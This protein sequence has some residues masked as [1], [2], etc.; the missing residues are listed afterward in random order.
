MRNSLLILLIVVGACAPA[1]KQNRGDEPPPVAR[2]FRGVW[3]ASVSNIDWPSKPGLPVDEQKRELIA[4][5]DKVRQMKMNA[6][7]LQVRPA[8]DALYASALEPWSEYLTG[9][10]GQAPVPFYDPLEFAVAEAHQRGLE[11]HAWFNP[12]R[13]RHPS[14]QGEIAATHLR[15]TRPDI[16]H[17]YGKHLWMDPGEPDVRKQTLAV[18]LDVVK[19]YDIDGI[20]LDDYFYPYQERDSANNIIPFPD[21]AS[22]N[23]YV[24]EGGKLDRDDWRRANVDQLIDEMYRAI[25][26]SKAWV[27]FG[28]SP[29]GIWRPGYPPQVKG[30]DAYA[31]LYADSKKWLNNGWLDYWTPQ[32]YWPMAAPEQSYPAL[33][34]WWVSENTHHRHVWP[35]NA[36]YRVAS[37]QQNWPAREIVDQIAATRAQPGATGNIHFSMRTFLRNQAGV[38][39]TV[40]ARAYTY[41]ALPPHTPWLD[42]AAPAAPV[43]VFDAARHRIRLEKAGGEGPLWYVVWLRL[44]G[45][46][47]AEVVSAHQ[48]EYEL[49]RQPGV[50]PDEVAVT[51]VDRSGNESRPTRIRLN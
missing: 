3:V 9:T 50:L 30:F 28:I 42:D 20:H 37:R 14:A 16:V 22:F 15:N 31:N 47:Y 45:V 32:L 23:R 8:A 33:L 26:Q 29:F 25:K 46:W 24:R 36:P 41:F 1:L 39:D 51:A 18:V 17:V 21:N 5:F 6:V 13:A 38:A 10:M 27:K 4:I 19:R 34:A 2:E 44:S 48:K 7:I 11:L 43:V 12:Y 35:G 49:L 40:T